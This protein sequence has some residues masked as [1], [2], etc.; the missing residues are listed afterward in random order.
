MS[1]RLVA[2]S[3][4]NVRTSNLNYPKLK[5][6]QVG[7]FGRI[8]CLEQPMAS[9]VHTLRKPRIVNGRA[10]TS[11]TK[12]K[13]GTEFEDF[14]K[15]FVSQPICLGD[16][17]T[18]LERGSDPEHC[19]L[20]AEAQRGDVADTPKQRYAM[21][22]IKYQTKPGS[23]EIQLPFQVQCVVWVFTETVFAKLVTINNE[24]QDLRQHDLTLGPLQAPVNF[25][26]FDIGV[27]MKAEWLAD[28]S[29]KTLTVQTFQQNR[30]GDLMALIGR[31]VP[32]RYLEEDL[33]SIRDA[34]NIANGVHVASPFGAV[35]ADSLASGLDGLM[36]SIGT[37]AA[38][39]P[40]AVVSEPLDSL[41]GSLTATMAAPVAVAAPV[42]D[43]WASAP[44]AA[45][46]VVDPLAALTAIQPAAQP[47]PV[48]VPAAVDP[49][50]ALTATMPAPVAVAAP[51]VAAPVVA[52]AVVDPLAAL[53][54]PPVT[55]VP[56]AGKAVSFD[57]L[58]KGL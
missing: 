40:A 13:D 33:Q 36:G 52:P 18:L 26:R 25:Q 14:V 20:C 35:G 17:G 55:A 54:P 23:A 21:H 11:L 50:A 30:A 34:W 43:P 53:T 7:E 37:P 29:R 4:Q 12:R 8:V 46:A 6:N 5:L 58:M 31:E 38:A 10:V 41:L 56:V 49:L 15:D 51:V 16:E 39:N 2:F 32:R 28:D 27:S 44:V 47:A 45:P 57:D 19:P 24:V 22:V 3:D 48:A 1:G 9:F 42:A